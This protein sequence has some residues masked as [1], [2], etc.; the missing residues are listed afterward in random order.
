MKE[1]KEKVYHE[2]REHLDRMP[3]GYPATKSGIE[4]KILKH[5]FQPDQAQIATFLSWKWKKLEEIH[6]TIN[7]NEIS[8][9]QLESVLNE[10]V[11]DGLI[12]YKYDNNT[13]LYAN[14]P[15]V[16]GF[17]E[18]QLKRLDKQL[19]KDVFHYIK[20]A[21]GFEIMRTQISQLRTVPIEQSIESEIKISTYDNIR[22]IFEKAKPPFAVTNC[23]CK[24][25]TDMIENPCKITERREICM[26]V[27]WM[28]QLYVD[29]GW[30]REISKKEALSILKKNEEDG[31]ILNVE[32]TQEPLFFCGCCTCCCGLTAGLKKLHNP[33]KLAH[34]NFYAQVDSELC[35]G[36]GTCIDRCQMEAIT[37]EE[38]K[39]Q[40]NKK[41]CIGCGNC[42][43]ICPSDALSLN[44]IKNI[45][46]PPETSTKLYSSILSKKNQ[47]KEKYQKFKSNIN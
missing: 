45:K 4:I 10:M 16:V 18:Y 39:A 31:L 27:D 23:I 21:F 33:S 19:V 1:N 2:L 44:I 29:Q 46:K 17:Y 42:V 37:F 28:A 40:I 43:Y 25:A 38:N 6:K 26:A 35:I 22:E 7:K 5:L 24:K 13:K 36:C 20:E 8:I 30:A 41:R 32:N 34:N 15:L 9:N 3:I 11:H 12:N 47:L 14:A